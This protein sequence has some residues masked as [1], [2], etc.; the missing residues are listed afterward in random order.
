MASSKLP[1]ALAPTPDDISMLLAAQS[2]IGNKNG[3]HQ[4]AS[5]VYKRRVDGVNIINLQKTWE[6]I[7]FA[8]RVIAAIENPADVTV[9]SARPYGQRAVLKFA[10]YTGA[11]AI[12][13]RFTPG[14]F[15]NYITKAFREPRLIIVTDPRTD[16]QAVKE[17]SYG[18]IPV[19]ALC[20][21]DSPLAWVD[22][23]RLRV[24]S[25]V[26]LTLFLVTRSFRS[27][28]L[29][30][31]TSPSPAT[32]NP[33]TRSASFGSSSPAKSS[34]SAG[35]SGASSRGPLWST[36]SFTGIRKSKRR[37]RRR[38]RRFLRLRRLSGVGKRRRER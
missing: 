6:K 15:T 30:T 31:S 24:L 25:S 33:S 21:T 20:D 4:M 18:N 10:Q 7:V 22:E 23:T 12:A 2:H 1:A 35:P 17:A 32:T 14:T 29:A 28:L 34:V 5:Y 9:I 37:T 38:W 36:C 27:L 3:G 16:H 19:I 8:A 26:H 13:G 11:T